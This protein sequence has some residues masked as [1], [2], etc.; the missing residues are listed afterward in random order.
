MNDII[1]QL[2]YIIL[3]LLFINN[4]KGKQADIFCFSKFP[5]NSIKNEQTQKEYFFPK[6]FSDN[7]NFSIECEPGDKVKISS[8]SIIS[9]QQI[10]DFLITFKFNENTMYL[11]NKN[12]ISIIDDIYIYIDIPFET[13]CKNSNDVIFSKINVSIDFSLSSY[14]FVKD[15]KIQS[16]D[17]LKINIIDFEQPKNI[18]EDN[19]II[20]FNTSKNYDLN[21]TFT[22][23]SKYPLIIRYKGVA[24]TG[25]S[26]SHNECT[27]RIL[28]KIPLEK[29]RIL[30]DEVTYYKKN[31][32]SNKNALENKETIEKFFEMGI[33]IFDIKERFFNDICFLYSEKRGDMVLD[34]RIHFIYQNYSL[35]ERGCKLHEIN[36]VSYEFTCECSESI[37]KDQE[38]QEAKKDDDDLELH[39]EFTRNTITEEFSNIFFETNFEVLRCFKGLLTPEI[40]F[41]NIGSIFTLILISIQ[42]ICCTFFCKNNREIRRYFYNE[43]MKF[44]AN[45]PLKRAKTLATDHLKKNNDLNKELQ[46]PDLLNPIQH[47]ISGRRKRKKTFINKAHRQGFI[48]TFGVSKNNDDLKENV[49]VEPESIYDSPNNKKNKDKP[50]DIKIFNFPKKKNNL[51]SNRLTLE[52]DLESSTH[53][54]MREENRNYAIFPKFIQNKNKLYKINLINRKKSNLRKYSE[55]SKKSKDISFKEDVIFDKENKKNFGIKSPCLISNSNSF[56]QDRDAKDIKTGRKLSNEKLIKDSINTEEQNN[57]NNL[58]FSCKHNKPKFSNKNLD[59]FSNNENISVYDKNRANNVYNDPHIINENN[60]KNE[61]MSTEQ[62]LNNETLVLEVIESNDKNIN[63]DSNNIYNESEENSGIDEANKDY[64]EMHINKNLDDIDLNELDFDEAEIYE[65]REFCKIFCFLLKERQLIVNTFCVKEIIKPFPI[66]LIVFI[67]VISCY[68]V[69]NGF[70]FNEE[71]VKKIFRR[72][73][74]GF[75]FFIVDSFERIVYSSIVAAIV[76]IIIGLMFKSD[77]KLRTI[78]KKYRNNTIMRN[79]EI[80][81]IYKSIRRLNTIF[82][83]FN[84]IIM[85]VFWLYLYS[86]CG[87]YRNCQLD[88]VESCYLI[89]MIMNI[90]PIIICLLLAALRKCGLKCRIEF[91][92]KVSVWISENT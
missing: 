15:R 77:K 25:I 5:L 19:L 82:T 88:W 35:C 72:K 14:V 67:F 76:N 89:V 30:D 37:R 84:F 73:K 11:Y 33:N 64:V 43:I 45:P 21:N 87:V 24:S 23:Y 7:H 12:N 1:F 47:P 42:L 65:R 70:L 27:I 58:Y 66:K 44:R 63:R 62:P 2:L 55:L 36:I 46:M 78:Q 51:N 91:F 81:K 71:Y 8:I 79:G 6:P 68:L 60:I 13:Y 32:F 38:S 85:S 57:I 49:F 61:R 80:V 20:N 75:Y 52:V 69:I 83:I 41:H 53:R 59:Y 54:K 28:R 90:F 17:R 40:F 48:N 22:V 92:Y 74:K 3:I 56:T 16:L 86:F 26:L 29:K 31:I 18:E 34:D 39:E 9:K 50:S 4:I 10:E